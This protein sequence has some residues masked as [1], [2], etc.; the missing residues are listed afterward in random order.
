MSTTSAETQYTALA[1][2]I[3]TNSLGAR[4]R[5]GVWSS[6]AKRAEPA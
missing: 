5:T 6:T 3:V 2:G 1:M 4:L